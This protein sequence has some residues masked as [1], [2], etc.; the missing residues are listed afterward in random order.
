MNE[1][2]SIVVPVYN[3]ETEIVACVESLCAQSY[4]RLEIILVDDGSSDKS[5]E[6]LQQLEL[7]D[8]RIIAIH[9]DNQGVT[10][11]RLAG[12]SRA[13]GDYIGFVDG[14]DIVEPQ[15]YER[16]LHNAQI[17]HADI[18]H[19]GYQ[20]VFPDGRVHYF[21]N[22]KMTME[23]DRE[24]GLTDLI[25]NKYIE[26]GLWTKLFRRELFSGL[27]EQ[28][29]RSIK[30]NEDLLMNFILFM[31]AEKAVFEDICPYHYIVRS[32]SASRGRINH[33]KIFDPIKVKEAIVELAPP[34]VKETAKKALCGTLLD[35]YNSLAIVDRKTFC[36][37]K[38]VI[39]EQITLNWDCMKT[40]NIRR[41][42]IAGMIRFFPSLYPTI[43]KI[44][45]KYFQRSLY[46]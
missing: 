12:V 28:M 42:V 18:S 37:E 24:K 43:Y 16:L 7:K 20:M 14:D 1:T 27:A 17:Y 8:N 23:Q 11:A 38:R 5:W 44:Y 45:A 22:S 41:K 10:A 40:L 26:P 21:Y 32:S 3:L 36:D 31:G 6:I 4:S 19:C 30:I 35:V 34:E 13:S 25:M 39:R 15:M 2:I 46:R 29:D 33:N 9:Q